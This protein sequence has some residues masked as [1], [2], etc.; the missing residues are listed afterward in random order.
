M[1]M[2]SFLRS[3]AKIKFLVCSFLYLCC[4]FI[5]SYP[6]LT[7]FLHS[8]TFTMSTPVVTEHKSEPIS[9][10]PVP[11]EKRQTFLAQLPQQQLPHSS[12]ISN[13][14][15]ALPHGKKEQS[16]CHVLNKT[17]ACGLI[18]GNNQTSVLL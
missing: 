18:I 17:S 16:E 3:Y 8:S 7:C 1:K 14:T 11:H 13:A 9:G 15:E 10:C 4:L 2:K 6:V 5:H 12:V